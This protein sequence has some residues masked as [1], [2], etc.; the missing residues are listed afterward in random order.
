MEASHY[1]TTKL[2][3]SIKLLYDLLPTCRSRLMLIYQTRRLEAYKYE[4]LPRE[5]SIRLMK[6]ERIRG[7]HLIYCT[8]QEANLDDAPIFT[9]LSYTW[10]RDRHFLR[11]PV[12]GNERLIICDHRYISVPE[13]LFNALITLGKTQLAGLLWIDSVC[14]NQRNILEQSSQ[15]N[16]MGRIFQAAETVVVWLGQSTRVSTRGIKAIATM[17]EFSH[18]LMND[19]TLKPIA[20]SDQ[21]LQLIH[22]LFQTH[23]YDTFAFLTVFCRSWFHRVWIVQEVILSRHVRFYLGLHEIPFEHILNSMRVLNA[24]M[25]EILAQLNFRFLDPFLR[26]DFESCTRIFE[27]R[28]ALQDGNPGTL[29]EYLS[30]GRGR[31]AKDAKDKVYSLLSIPYRE[32]L[33]HDGDQGTSEELVADY[34]KSTI[35]VYTDCARYLLKHGEGLALLSMVGSYKPLVKRELPSWV[36]DLSAPLRPRPLGSCGTHISETTPR[37]ASQFF[38]QGEE[39][40]VTAARW[41]IISA[42]SETV[43]EIATWAVS[44]KGVSS[45]KG[46]MLR[47]ITQ[48]GSTYAPTDEG[49]MLA[50]SRTLIGDSVDDPQPSSPEF[51]KAFTHC[52][53]LAI[54]G[55]LGLS[56]GLT[57]FITPPSALVPLTTAF[58]DFIA[59]YDS[60]AYPFRAV[61]DEYLDTMHSRFSPPKHFNMGF[62]PNLRQSI[63]YASAFFALASYRRLF[64]TEKGYLGMG[65]W[66]MEK[67]DVVFLVPGADAPI[68]LRPVK[69]KWK[70]IGEAYIHGIMR[71]EATDLS[72]TSIK[73]V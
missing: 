61:R 28:N 2:L 26:T 5:D 15:V 56:G 54:L 8:L 7:K 69:D 73:I 11:L 57:R 18:E 25:L 38:I 13:N 27:A 22:K 58:E 6:I 17:Y 16:M 32:S 41:D 24:S 72:Y 21:V 39:L 60:P 48:L 20:K 37:A 45:M 59:T 63:W 65:P 9:A 71:G 29:K 47:I 46:N 34:S 1:L 19:T 53:V 35:Q 33:G 64:T 30:L 49:M 70:L 44:P 62:N 12:D 4:K 14:I 36:P 10:Q 50:V 55:I 42:T 43:N 31:S 40:S 66:N 68:V 52:V 67:D 23:K 3:V 51:A